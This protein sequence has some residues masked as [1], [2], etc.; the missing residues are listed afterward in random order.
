MIVG[1]DGIERR[2]FLASSGVLLASPALL[3][4]QGTN[5][6]ALVIGN[7]KY[8]WESS[9]PNVRRDAADVAKRFDALGLKTNLIIDAGREA[10]LSALARLQTEA[11]TSRLA[12][13][14]FAGHGVDSQKGEFLVPVDADLSTPGQ[15]EALVSM[16]EVFRATAPAAHRLMVFDNCRNNPS[17]G[18]RQLDAQRKAAQGVDGTRRLNARGPNQAVFFS[19]APGA[20]ALD[21]PA[22]HNSPFVAAF[23]RQLHGPLIDFDMIAAKLR[24]DLLIST[25]GQQ[26]AFSRSNYR[27]PIALQASSAKAHST[28]PAEVV[29]RSI[30]PARLIELPR[31]YAFAEENGLQLPPGLVAIRP[32]SASRDSDMVGSFQCKVRVPQ[33]EFPMVFIVLSVNTKKEARVVFASLGNDK[34]PFWRFTVGKVTGPEIFLH[35]REAGTHDLFLEWKD[36]NSGTYTSKPDS[37][38]EGSGKKF[39]FPVRADLKRLDG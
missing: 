25:E 30:E 31:A 4:A 28:G 33:R 6:V 5:G 3:C 11:K 16:N 14:Y 29:P 18:W 19:T 1:C 35:S 9:L 22:G 36:R 34:N 8:K 38:A 17:D 7:S 23:L 24:R 39:G 21:G 37:H 15:I 12:A 2:T 20:I 13:I 10:M 27:E 32:I 26:L